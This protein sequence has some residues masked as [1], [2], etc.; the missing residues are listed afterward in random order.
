[1]KNRPVD[2][3]AGDANYGVIGAGYSRHRQPD[4]RIAARI[5]A[6]LGDAST[7]VN[8]GAGAGSYEPTH[9]RVVAVEPSASMREQR[10]P[11]LPRAINAVAERLPFRDRSFDGAMATFTIHQW[12]DLGAGL[13]EMR[14]VTRGPVV[15][16]TC[17]PEDVQ[18]F[19]LNDYAP[20]VLAAEARRYPSMDDI[21]QRLGTRIR[22]SPVPIPFDCSDGFNE[23]YF[24]RPDILLDPGA[25]LSCSAWSF[26]SQDVARRY[27]DHLASDLLDGTWDR[28]YGHLRTQREFSGSLYL[29][30]SDRS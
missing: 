14:R 29:V 2:G 11:H 20:D 8:V 15:I 16:L 23:A 18:A 26:V 27:V 19:W 10:P 7:V 24:G 3:S 22:I 25:R 4:P 13:S 28:K 21:E 9:H 12:R 1:V 17:A 5:H 30:V 6:A